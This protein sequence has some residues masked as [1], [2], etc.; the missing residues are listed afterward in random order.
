[1]FDPV[2]APIDGKFLAQMPLMLNLVTDHG[3]L[4]LTFTPSGPVASFDEWSVGANRIEIAK[5]LP[6]S[7]AALDDIIESKRAADRP[8]DRIA[9]PY[10]EALRERLRRA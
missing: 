1:M 9:L 3:D 4:D 5:D 7:I 10:L 6:V 2:P 8:K